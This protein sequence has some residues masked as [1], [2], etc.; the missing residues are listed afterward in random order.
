MSKRVHNENGSYVNQFSIEI[1]VVAHASNVIITLRP[2]K[3]IY[4]CVIAKRRDLDENYG[5]D[6]HFFCFWW[7]NKFAI[8]EKMIVPELK[9]IDGVHA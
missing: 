6:T 1:C 7:R 3:F 4:G 9:C 2:S 8:V 5:V